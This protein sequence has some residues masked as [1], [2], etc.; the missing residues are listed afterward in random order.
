MDNSPSRRRTRF[1]LVTCLAFVVAGCVAEHWKHRASG[2]PGLPRTQVS[3]KGSSP[4]FKVDFD[5]FTGQGSCVWCHPKASA[6]WAEEESF[7]KDAYGLLNET[8][9]Q[10]PE[11]VKCHV[12]AFNQEGVYPLE[13]EAKQS[14]RSQGFSFG[15][16]P[17]VNR[18]FLGVQC[19][20]CH[21]PNCGNKYTPEQQLETCLRC[22][23]EECPEFTD[24]E[25]ETALERMRHAATGAVEEVDFDAYVGLDA[26]FMCHRTV[27][28]SSRREQ[29]AH[30]LA[31]EVLG[32]EE[33]KDPSCLACH[34]TGFNRDGVY[35][36][37]A[38]RDTGKRR[39]GYTFGGDPES[40]RA[41]EGVQC[42]ACH[43][44]NCGTYTEEEQIEQQCLACHSGNCEHDR[45]FRWEEAI[46]KVR[47]RPPADYADTGPSKVSIDWYDL[48]TGKQ[49]ANAWQLPLLIILSNPP[50]G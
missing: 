8:Q 2:M 33:R 34:T 23:N 45:G 31:F 43:G 4:Y 36:L 30:L 25:P 21:G 46:E 16:D 15:G 29:Q 32:P 27:F 47:H 13:V 19:E 9:R 7:H 14:E 37:E 5:R 28:E 35:P 22:H 40:N 24:F 6:I 3:Y 50:D 49:V 1:A 20:A 38:G 18:H 41:F 44:I 26:C 12:T 10:R 17:D 11:C 48:E 42:E 39:S